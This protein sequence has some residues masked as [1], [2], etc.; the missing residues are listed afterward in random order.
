MHARLDGGSEALQDP[1]AR[2][3][4]IDDPLHV[5]FEGRFEEWQAEQTKKNFERP[6]VVSLIALPAP[7]SWLFAGVHDSQGCRWDATTRRADYNLTRRH[8]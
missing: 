5:Y 1:L 7:H 6:L 2:W 3:N 8:H 4:G